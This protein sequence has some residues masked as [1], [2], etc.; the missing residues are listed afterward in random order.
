MVIVRAIE[1]TG[2]GIA[3]WLAP[4]NAPRVEAPPP[5]PDGPL[6][7]ERIVILGAHRDDPLA[8]RLA[9]AG[10]PIMAAVGFSTT[11]L[12]ISED[13]PFGRFVTAHAQ[14]RHANALRET[15]A[16]ISICTKTELNDQ[17]G[18]CCTI[19][20]P[21]SKRMSEGSNQFRCAEKP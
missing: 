15:G 6:K 19:S 18:D 11:R 21:K 7:G 3:G 16:A 5:A 13:Q 2:M 9:G 14:Y 17:F 10:A 4:A 8:R 1:H 12:V 20:S